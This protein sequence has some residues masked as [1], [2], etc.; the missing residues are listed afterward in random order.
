MAG[1]SAAV[2]AAGK[3]AATAAGK[4]SAAADENAGRAAAAN[5]PPARGAF[6]TVEGGDGAGK[7]THLD[8]IARHLRAG[9]H[10]VVQ[11]RE[12]GGTALGERLRGLLLGGDGD[13]GS[14]GGGD[15]DGG[16]G[17]GDGDG[18]AFAFGAR[19]ELLLVFAA[20]AQHIDEV[21]A[22]AL[23]AGRWVLCDRFTDATYAYQGGGRGLDARAIAALE[24]WTQAGLQPDLTLLLDVPV[25]V[26]QA[27]AR[28]RGAAADRFESESAAFKQAVRDAYLARAA[29]FPARI[30]RIDA[31]AGIAQVQT[32][33]RAELDAFQRRR[34]L[35]A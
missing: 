27:R 7:T 19:A 34:R 26:G 25:A 8:C 2:A 3:S 1:N 28:R 23:A 18:D 35:R 15:G 6:I 10:T 4:N 13:G 14:D 20:R 30:K 21:I 29:Q 31:A 16:S 32:E 17:Y 11:S 33:L 5:S 9:G 12:P 22:P 24:D